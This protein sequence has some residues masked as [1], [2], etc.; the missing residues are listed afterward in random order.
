MFDYTD[1][2]VK[3]IIQEEFKRDLVITPIGNHELERHLVYRIDGLYPYPVVLKLFCKKNRVNR[4]I[5][6]LKLLSNSNVKTPLLL[7][8]GSFKEGT[9][10]VIT[11]LIKGTSLHK[12]Y[13]NIND[14]KKKRILYDMGKELALIHSYDTFDFFG[15]WD[16]NGNS[17]EKNNDFKSVFKKRAEI[18]INN[19]Q[20]QKLPHT[21][22]FNCAINQLRDNYTLLES[23][24]TSR[25]CH[26]DFGERNILVTVEKNDLNL[27]GVIDFEQ[28]LPWDIDYELAYIHYKLTIE[29]RNHLNSFMDG[30]KSIHNYTFN[31]DEKTRIYLLYKGLEIC[32]WS[33]RVAR[34]FYFKG[35]KIVKN[36]L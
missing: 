33:Y 26:N 7:S 2:K 24:R 30:Y 36:N 4:E 17:S 10:W 28:A 23:V 8:R 31:L 32:S 29:G 5:A 18:T 25:L 13:V 14:K 34:D 12:I 21:S 11:K 27:T 16:R 20:K 1:S 6:S 19:L 35:L 22:I 15:N 9:D 3:E